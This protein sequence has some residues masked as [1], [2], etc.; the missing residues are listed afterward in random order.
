MRWVRECLGWR[1]SMT[2]DLKEWLSGEVQCIAVVKKTGR[3]CPH[4]GDYDCNGFPICG[5]HRR[6]R[7][8]ELEASARRWMAE[9]A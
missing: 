3:R 4:D 8:D 9:D 6:R 7:N 1:V 5:K 2:T